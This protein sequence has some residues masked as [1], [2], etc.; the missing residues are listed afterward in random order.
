MRLE[1]TS[2]PTRQKIQKLYEDV[3]YLIYCYR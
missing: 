1:I 3:Y 2:Y